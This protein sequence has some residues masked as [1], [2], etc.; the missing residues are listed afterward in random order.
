MYCSS[1]D[2]IHNDISIVFQNKGGGGE[3][4]WAAGEIDFTGIFNSSI[5]KQTKETRHYNF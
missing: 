1:F 4:V 5:D 3:W 2:T